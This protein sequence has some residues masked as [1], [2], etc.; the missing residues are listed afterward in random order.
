[1]LAHRPPRAVLAQQLEL[2]G[3][4]D[5]LELFRLH[6]L[7]HGA[8][9]QERH[10]SGLQQTP[11]RA[12]VPSIRIRRRTPSTGQL[13]HAQLA[14][15]IRIV[16]NRIV[17]VVQR[18][19]RARRPKETDRRL[20]MIVAI[21]DLHAALLLQRMNRYRPPALRTDLREAGATIAQITQRRHIGQGAAFHDGHGVVVAEATFERLLHD[22]H[23]RIE[24]TRC[25]HFAGVE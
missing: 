18:I 14:Q 10:I 25:E 20:H 15:L 3:T 11:E 9:L 16:T 7:Q 5:C 6:H 19:D 2:I 13:A 23:E 21:G 22:G 8:M 12:L 1:M 4:R 17:L 24:A